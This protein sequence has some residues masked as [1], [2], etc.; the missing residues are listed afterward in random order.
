MDLKTNFLLIVFGGYTP[1]TD[2]E[3][4]DEKQKIYKGTIVENPS[5]EN[6]MPFKTI[7]FSRSYLPDYNELDKVY[8]EIH[9]TNTELIGKEFFLVPKE[10]LLFGYET[11][12]KNIII[13]KMS[14]M[15]RFGPRN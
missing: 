4:Y 1:I 13:P 5:Q 2:V 9:I 15:K 6:K 7:Y 10:K 12:D 11:W 14:E 3:V 8:T